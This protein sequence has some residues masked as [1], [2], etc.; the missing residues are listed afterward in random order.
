MDALVPAA[1]PGS[2]SDVRRWMSMRSGFD[3]GRRTKYI[4]YSHGQGQ[5]FGSQTAAT[6]SLWSPL[7]LATLL[8][9]FPSVSCTTWRQELMMGRDR[10]RSCEIDVVSSLLLLAKLSTCSLLQFTDGTI[11]GITMDDE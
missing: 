9:G 7:G 4:V 5:L 6:P 8:E 11:L 3:S 10:A 2:M 1:Q